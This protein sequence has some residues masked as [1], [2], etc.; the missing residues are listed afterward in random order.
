MAEYE[1][2]LR[3]ARGARAAH[4]LPRAGPPVP[5]GPHRLSTYRAHRREREAKI[6]AALAAPGTLA[7]L[8]A[9]AYDD[10]P[11]L[12]HPVAE[13]GCLAT[14]VKLRAEGR[15]EE[16]NGVWRRSRGPNQGPEPPSGTSPRVGIPSGVDEK[17]R[18]DVEREP[19]PPPKR[20]ETGTAFQGTGVAHIRGHARPLFQVAPDRPHPRGSL[21]L[22]RRLGRGGA[23]HPRERREG[24]ERARERRR[25]PARRPR[26]VAP[27]R[28][29]RRHA[30]A[31]LP[32]RAHGGARAP[33]S[34]AAGPREAVVQGR[35]RPRPQRPRGARLRVGSR[36]ARSPRR[37]GWR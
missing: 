10:T 23:A 31:H 15:A 21:R 8:T 18:L 19:R 11:P 1:R 4:A 25:R 27:R 34:G 36:S 35:V 30:A 7:E 26:A 17:P 24:A 9:R 12:I 14:L 28:L 13:R 37:A 32:H 3:A 16:V 33:R 5:D 29:D 22:R 20:A 6:V 2:R